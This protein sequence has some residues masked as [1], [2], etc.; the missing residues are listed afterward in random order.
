M[1]NFYTCHHRRL[2]LSSGDRRVPGSGFP[3][4]VVALL[5]IGTASAQPPSAAPEGW[6]CVQRYQPEVSVGTFWP[7]EVAEGVER[8]DAP[9]AWELVDRITE[10]AVTPE[11]AR[12]QI[13]KFL[14]AQS[15]DLQRTATHLVVALR[16][17]TNYKRDRVI[18]GIA[19]FS[20]RQQLMLKR[21][22][23]QA[24]KIEVL[25]TRE[26]PDAGA[27]EDLQARQTWDVRVFE[28][29]EA[30][31]NHLCEQPVLLEQKFFA[32]G[33]GVVTYLRERDK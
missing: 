30:L 12:E 5:I 2:L 31:A 22:E 4:A 13:R 1:K 10:R 27:L 26:V 9:Q 33:R 25:R 15:E 14:E 11:Q 29:R 6:P 16:D 18:E 7:H 8:N 21:I 32:V 3:G 24:K 20:A 19:R 23:E 28:E 17:L